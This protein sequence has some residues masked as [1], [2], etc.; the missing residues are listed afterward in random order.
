MRRSASCDVALVGQHRE[1]GVREARQLL[2][3]A[4]TT[5]GAR[6]ADVQ[7]ADAAGEVDEDVAVDIGDSGPACLRDDDREVGRERLRPRPR[8]LA[9]E[10][11]RC[12]RGP[13]TAVSESDDAGS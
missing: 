11:L 4:A 10:D 6:V 1:V 5:R 2:L 3:A 9:L 12:E 13:G 7:A 8:C